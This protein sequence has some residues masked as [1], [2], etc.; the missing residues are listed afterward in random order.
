MDRY[1]YMLP[2]LRRAVKGGTLTYVSIKGTKYSV[3]RLI[4]SERL[5]PFHPKLIGL[6]DVNSKP[7]V[8]LVS[9]LFPF[10]NSIYRK[11][12]QFEDISLINVSYKGEYEIWSFL[13]P[14]EKIHTYKEQILEK[15]ESVSEIQKSSINAS[16]QFFK[17]R[18][19]EY[20]KIFLSSNTLSLLQNLKEIGYFDFP[21][22]VTIDEAASK[23]G[24][25][26]GFISKTTRKI[27]DV[28]GTNH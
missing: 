19:N 2:I 21:R 10:N 22:K 27:F 24:T 9:F 12:N 16:N 6:L 3:K 26:K 17:E 18:M 28:V 23:L 8:Y 13:I 25:S 20:L 7:E 11:F 1:E 4:F 14:F 15:L 5:A